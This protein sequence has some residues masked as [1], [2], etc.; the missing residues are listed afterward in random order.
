MASEWI[1]ED[2]E[3]LDKASVCHSFVLVRNVPLIPMA[4]T[5]L[6]H[7]RVLER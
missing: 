2:H 3:V 7:K 6:R 5:E 1:S 4:G